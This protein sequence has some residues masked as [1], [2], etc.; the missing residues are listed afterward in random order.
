MRKM[1]LSN[2]KLVSVEVWC[3]LIVLAVTYYI[4]QRPAWIMTLQEAE[5][6]NWFQSHLL[7]VMTNNFVNIL[8]LVVGAIAAFGGIFMGLLQFPQIRYWFFYKVCKY[9]EN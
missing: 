2:K 9:E 7:F 6:L 5:T 3:Y 8:V 1:L 4:F